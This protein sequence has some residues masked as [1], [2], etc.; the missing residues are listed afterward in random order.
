MSIGKNA[1]KRVE[2]NGYSKVKTE[3]PDMINSTVIG[4]TDPQVINMIEKSVEKKPVAKATTA[5]KTTSTAKKATS[6]K[7]VAQKVEEVKKPAPATKAEE[8]K[9]EPNKPV[10]TVKKA[11]IK[12]IKSENGKTYK[13]GDELPVY[14]L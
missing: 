6:S 13:C 11:P 12:P 3:A 5:K 14:L 1:I 4:A 7:P 8:V 9:S 10:K 2:N